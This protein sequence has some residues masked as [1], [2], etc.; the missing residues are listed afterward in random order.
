MDDSGCGCGLRLSL[1]LVGRT[2]DG[3]P[4]GR[5]GGAKQAPPCFHLGPSASLLHSQVQMEMPWRPEAV[6]TA[7]HYRRF[8]RTRDES[9]GRG[10]DC[11]EN[12]WKN[13]LK[14]ATTRRMRMMAT[15]AAEIAV[16]LKC[17]CSPIKLV[18]SHPPCAL[19]SS[20]RELQMLKVVLSFRWS[21]QTVRN[22]PRHRRRPLRRRQPAQQ[23]RRIGPSRLM[24][25]EQ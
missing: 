23:R 4:V 19:R 9:R 3:L 18:F 17:L 5:R 12:G 11:G 25:L 14:F 2:S 15:S 21:T 13:V 10:C 6:S 24:M 8:E 20:I 16:H 22:P 7:S 1:G